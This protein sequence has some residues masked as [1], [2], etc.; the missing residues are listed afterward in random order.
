MP[1]ENIVPQFLVVNELALEGLRNPW[2]VPESMRANADVWVDQKEMCAAK[3][4]EPSIEAS[5]HAPAGRTFKIGIGYF[6]PNPAPIC[7]C[8]VF[9]M[10]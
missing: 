4:V 10:V 6:A 5:I 2:H 9:S 7:A 3:K 8:R 1:I